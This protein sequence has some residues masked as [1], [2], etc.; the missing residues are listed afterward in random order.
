MILKQFEINKINLDKHKLILF[1][2]KNEGLKSSASKNLTK[3]IDKVYNY[4]ERDILDDR[5]NFLENIYNKSLFET[6]KFIIVKRTTDKIIKI[7]EKI[8]LKNLEKINIIFNSDNLEKKSKLRIFF[9]KNENY[10]CVPF[11]PDNEQTLAKLA[12]DYLKNKK[13]LISPENINLIL[14]KCNYDRETLQNELTKIENFSKNKKKITTEDIVKLTNLAENYSIT[15]LIDSCLAK[16]TKKIKYILN[17]N[18]FSNEETILIIRTFLNKSKKILKLSEEFKEK[19]NLDLVISS[20]KPPIFWKDK[21]ITKVQISKWAPEKIKNLI[22]N[23]NDLE[24][25]IKKNQNNPVNL[26]TDFI[27]EQ[28]A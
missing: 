21:E 15:E 1:Y 4:D 3:N 9:E 14:N 22:Y 6:K 20:A 2:G 24:L 27:L 23:I 17:E 16:N 28:S 8:S 18:N 5:E 12:F 25:K 13:I 10:I 26:I 19:K 11:Y 7:I